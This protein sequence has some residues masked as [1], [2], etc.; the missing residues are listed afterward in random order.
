MKCC[1]GERFTLV[2]LL[3]VVAIISILT[4]I[5]MPSLSKA[6]SKSRA[7]VCKSNLKQVGLA[8]ALYMDN[9]DG[10]FNPNRPANANGMRWAKNAEFRS[11]L[12]WDSESK[13][14]MIPKSGACPG[15]VEKGADVSATAV[16]DLRTYGPFA[17]YGGKDYRG[18]RDSWIQDQSSMGYAGDVW[19][20]W[21]FSI[22]EF[23]PRHNNLANMVFVDGHVET[24]SFSTIAGSYA[25][26]KPW[27]DSD[28]RTHT[29]INDQMHP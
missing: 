12:N 17:I 14:W 29:N 20:G 8:N 15:A 1:C 21:Q 11:Y 5:L 28:G 27:V 22:N 16:K 26:R 23:D 19:G 13:N 7:V 6:R 18:L 24:G 10:W 9:N 2:E 25:V 3:V 4:S